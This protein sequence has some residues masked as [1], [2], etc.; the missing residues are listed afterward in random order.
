MYEL[1]QK[2]KQRFQF[3]HGTINRILTSTQTTFER[4]VANNRGNN[5]DRH[6]FVQNVYK[7]KKEPNLSMQFPILF[8]LSSQILL[9][10]IY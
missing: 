6:N 10:Q 2:D 9:Q 4:L 5:S 1:Y 3:M 8:F 7:E